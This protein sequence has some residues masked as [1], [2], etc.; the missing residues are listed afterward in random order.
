MFIRVCCL[1]LGVVAIAGAPRGSAQEDAQSIPR[2]WLESGPKL[3]AI[4]ERA[5]TLAEIDAGENVVS[6]QQAFGRIA[7]ASV[8]A[9]TWNTTLGGRHEFWPKPGSGSKVTVLDASTLAV[10]ASRTVPFRPL[11]VRFVNADTLAVVSDGQVSGDA[12]KEIRP[13]VT[14]LRAPKWEAAASIP[15]KTTPYRIWWKD[16]G[17][18]FYVVCETFKNRPAELVTIDAASGEARRA[19]LPEDTFATAP[20]PDGRPAYLVLEKSVVPLDSAGGLLKP[21]PLPGK[22]RVLFAPLPGLTYLHGASSGKTGTLQVLKDG[23][24]ARTI[25]LPGGLERVA[26]GPRTHRLYV[27]GNKVA[28]VLDS[29]TFEQVGRL[30]IPENKTDVQLDP[31]ERRLFVFDGKSLSIV[32]VEG[33]LPTGKVSVGGGFAQFMA[34]QTV[35]YDVV[36]GAFR[37]HP[38]DEVATEVSPLAFAA[39]GSHAMVYNA[40]VG[41]VG[42]VDTASLA[43]NLKVALSSVWVPGLSDLWRL[44]GGQRLLALRGRRAWLLD[45]EKG[46]LIADKEFPKSRVGWMSRGGLLFVRSPESTVALSLETLQP[47]HD[48]GAE[49][50]VP[51]AVL[52][53]NLGIAVHEAGRRF[54]MTTTAGVKMFDFGFKRVGTIE[55]VKRV[56]GLFRTGP[57]AGEPGEQR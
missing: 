23:Q 54:V 18:E 32:D 20:G 14:I 19:S 27:C 49:A 41:Q 13:A 38:S 26:Y 42:L 4:D 52:K 28:L 31:A 35:H 56:D 15:L 6:V 44:P 8:G 53:D 11:G 24:I 50:G 17:S 22:A 12:Q 25:E 40:T 36:G 10:L 16:G 30:T 7:V 1:V 51:E 29:E 57:P 21:L 34:E 33:K 45:L 37:V 55:G 48:F 5:S 2:W 9:Y 47:V 39:S 46:A 3:I 43:V